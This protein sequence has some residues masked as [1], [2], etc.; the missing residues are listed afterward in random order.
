MTRRNFEWNVVPDFRKCDDEQVS[1]CI[2]G[3]LY[4]SGVDFA[5]DANNLRELGITHIISVIGSATRG[6]QYI[7]HEGFAYWRITGVCD[8]PTATLLPHIQTVL[9]LY[10][11]LGEGDKLLIHCQMGVSRSS[12]LAIACVMHANPKWC[13]E[14]AYDTVKAARPCIA[15][16]PEFLFQIQDYFR[17]QRCQKKVRGLYADRE[18]FIT[19]SWYV[20]TCSKC[21]NVVRMLPNGSGLCECPITL[22]YVRTGKPVLPGD[23]VII[24]IE[25]NEKNE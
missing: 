12:S 4:V 11:A 25:T 13:I 15:P 24:E 5:S 8:D 14:Q 9:T 6:P 18:V 3:K 19:R 23:G 17:S 10:D 2:L 21:Q 16:E 1:Q 22:T 7:T 20:E